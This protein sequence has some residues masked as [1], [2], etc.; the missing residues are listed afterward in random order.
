MNYDYEIELINVCKSF[1]GQDVFKNLNIGFVKNKISVILGPSGCGKTTL[2]NIISGIEKVDFGKVVVNNNS[3][4]YIFQEDRLI[5]WLT[6]YENIAF[7]LK[8]YKNKKEMDNIIHKYLDIVKLNDHKDKLPHELSGGMKRRVAVARA[9]SYKSEL[10]LMDEPF[11]GLDVKLKQ[12]IIAE[13]L[14]IWQE[15]KRT[16]IMVTHDMEEA[17]ILGDK[18]YYL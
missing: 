9:F 12:Y 3:I 2:L 17:K 14:K 6:V 18:I 10:L 15:D 8:S 1:Q 7:T 16:V 4:S 11:K 13:F 5:P